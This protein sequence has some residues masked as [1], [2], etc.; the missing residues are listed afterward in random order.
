R[1]LDEPTAPA[2]D[3]YSGVL[4]DALGY[5]SMTP[6]ARQRAKSGVLIFSAA[7]GVVTP[8]DRI[9]AYRL[10]MG[11]SLPGIGR[12]SSWWKPRLAGPISSY[13]SGHL[14]VDCRSADY[15]AAW[16]VPADGVAVRVFKESA[17]TRSV[18]S[19]MAKRTRGE[20]A[21]TLLASGGPDPGTPQELLDLVSAEWSHAPDGRRAELQIGRAACR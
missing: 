16:K 7:F 8:S 15:A 6:A 10:A 21:R 13:A 2:H 3:V 9:P 1:L 14:I 4:Y 12:M 20:L 17:G 18:V 11:T 5:G 19:H